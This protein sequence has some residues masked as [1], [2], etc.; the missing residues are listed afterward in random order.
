LYRR[1]FSLIVLTWNKENNIEIIFN[2]C[3]TK[4]PDRDLNLQP[5][6]AC[7]DILA[8]APRKLMIS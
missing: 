2:N 3:D 1:E 4:T 5:F 8:T 6:D 7:S